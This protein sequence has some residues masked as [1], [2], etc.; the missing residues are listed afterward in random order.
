M[1]KPQYLK[2][3]F[4]LEWTEYSTLLR[5][6]GELHIKKIESQLINKRYNVSV[7]LHTPTCCKLKMKHL[8]DR[9]DGSYSGDCFRPGDHE[10]SHY[11]IYQCK[12]CQKKKEYLYSHKTYEDDNR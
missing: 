11:H 4:D 8:G 9:I 3:P 10:F 5:K 6:H 1:K 2:D 7:S 12:K